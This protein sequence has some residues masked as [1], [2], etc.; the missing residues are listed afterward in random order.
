MERI[1]DY[2]LMISN[3]NR[4][5]I[6]GGVNEME[7]KE[8]SLYLGECL[9]LLTYWYNN[10]YRGFID[11]IYIDP[12]FNSNRDYNVLFD[13]KLSED[14]FKDTWSN[15]TYL[16]E[17][18]SISN[19]SPN[20]YSF[21]KLLENT[22]MPKTYISYLTKMTIRCWYMREMLK[23]TGSFYYHCDPTMS[24]YIK[25]ILDYLYTSKNFKNEIIWKR[26]PNTGSLK[27]SSNMIPKNHDI[28]FWYTKTSDYTFHKIIIPYPKDELEWRFPYNDLDG[29]GPYHWNTLTTVSEKKIQQLRKDN[30]LKE[31][32]NPLAKHPYSYKVYLNKTKGGIAVSS[33]WD[34]INAIHGSSK[35]YGGYPTQKPEKLLERIIKSTTNEGD[36][37]ADF[38]M[39]GGTTII[40][41]ENLDRKWIGCDINI[42][43]IYIVKDRI[44]KSKKVLKD[45]FYIFGIPRSA[46]ELRKLVDDGILG[47]SKDSHISLQ[48]VTIKFYLKGVVG[49]E[50]AG[51]DGS[52]DGK[53]TFKFKKKIRIGI[54][55]ITSSA[56]KNHFNSFGSVLLKGAGEIGVY[57][58]FEDKVTSGMRRDAKSYG[59]LGGIDRLQILT[60]E[61]L[62]DKD[63]QYEIPYDIPLPT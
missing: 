48:N 12:P 42:R 56:T 41:A 17:L 45:N 7:P 13:S 20:L 8:N 55:Q 3:N 14:A 32:N 33:I 2:G 30:E 23:E 9:D 22:G 10:G 57:I 54:V 46:K 40:S 4:N 36:L 58:T 15:I 59:K 6:L 52:I 1:G 27:T 25:I 11:L 44:E 18:E 51:P 19:I 5:L 35:E 24:H 26:S 21:L 31:S 43:A 29:K 61:N 47:D 39:G 49:N 16:D 53:F 34:D 62:I 63:I 38:F 37:V 50:K 60:F 28:I